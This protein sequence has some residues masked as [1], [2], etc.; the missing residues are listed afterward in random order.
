MEKRP[1]TLKVKHDKDGAWF[2]HDRLIIKGHAEYLPVTDMDGKREIKL[3]FIGKVKNMGWDLIHVAGEMISTTEMTNI[4]FMKYPNAPITA[5]KR[6]T[7]IL[8]GD[9]AEE[10]AE[11]LNVEIRK[12]KTMWNLSMNQ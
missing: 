10:I 12:D 5:K 3:M 7:L 11:L 6:K 4:L 2:E 1:T 9:S 8:K